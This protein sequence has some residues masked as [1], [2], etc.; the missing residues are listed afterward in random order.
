[1]PTNALPIVLDTNVCLD[2]FV[3]ADPRGAPLADAM[4]ANRVRAFGSVDCRAEWLRVITEV[5]L[6]LGS[7]QQQA[8]D[9][10]HQR[11]VDSARGDAVQIEPRL[12]RCR[13][14]DDQKFLELAHQVGAR[15]LFSRDR[16][17]L[18]LNRRTQRISG[19]QVLVPEQFAEW[20]QA[21]AID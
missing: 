16:A 14:P 13:D 20:L 15:A 3:F 7:P 5:K 12:P 2:L 17:L 21:C 19:Y 8:A 1:M 9:A 6:G 18:V 4:R 11:W 10:E